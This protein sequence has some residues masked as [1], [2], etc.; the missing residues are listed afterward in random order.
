MSAGATPALRRWAA[1]GLAALGMQGMAVAQTNSPAPILPGSA[2]WASPPG[3]PGVQG[4]WLIGG[5]EKA[6]LYLFRVRLAKGAKIPPHTHPD[7]RSTTVLSGTIQVGFGDRFDASRMVSI[8]AGAIYVAPAGVAHY[9]WARDGEA[10][11]QESGVGP[12]GTSFSGPG[13]RH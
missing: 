11:Y 3:M 1:G 13:D 7:E 8:P 9:I 6:G 4:A 2:T 12:T 10:V 5:Q